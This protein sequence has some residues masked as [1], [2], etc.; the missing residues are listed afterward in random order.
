MRK[1]VVG[2]SIFLILSGF[3]LSWNLVSM[4]SLVP[5]DEEDLFVSLLHIWVGFFFIVIFPMY[6]W[7]HIYTHRRRLRQFSW[8]LLSGS[9]QLLSGIGLVLTGIIL[10]FYGDAL[11]LPTSLHYG[12]TFV[13]VVSILAHFWVPKNR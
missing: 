1:L 12:L 2:S 13:L 7:D 10:L 5:L 9:L 4:Q 6:A 11:E 8:T 3:V